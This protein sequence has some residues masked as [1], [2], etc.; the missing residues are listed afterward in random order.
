MSE[1]NY[2]YQDVVSTDLS[3]RLTSEWPDST[4]KT[5]SFASFEALSSS[6]SKAMNDE[7]SGLEL[8][9]SLTSQEERLVARDGS[10]ANF[11]TPKIVVVLN[12]NRVACNF[13]SNKY[14]QYAQA[15]LCGER[16]PL[17]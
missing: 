13:F 17:F 4:S 1:K 10:R 11:E 15:R 16:L 9:Q 8:H 6:P 14:V 12:V 5:A 7:S 2:Q 3:A